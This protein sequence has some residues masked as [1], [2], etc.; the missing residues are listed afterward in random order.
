MKNFQWIL[1]IVIVVIL[2]QTLPYKFLADPSSVHI[3]MALGIEPWGRYLS[4]IAEA[5]A[6]MLL[7]YNGTVAVG[8]TLSRSGFEF[9][10][11]GSMN[12]KLLREFLRS[13]FCF[14]VIW[15]GLYSAGINS[16]IFTFLISIISSQ[17]KKRREKTHNMS[18]FARLHSR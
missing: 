15:R 3:F 4:G 8:A 1:R 12:P 10:T 2:V 11:T 14:W 7:I 9:T 5:V 16:D 13:C 6:S 18:H 17:S